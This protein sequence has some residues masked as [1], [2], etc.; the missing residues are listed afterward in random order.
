[1]KLQKNQSLDVVDVDVD[2]STINVAEK[3]GKVL[4]VAH[5]EIVFS[6]MNGILN[7]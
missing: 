1:V 5:K 2:I 4:N 7:V 6:K 3:A